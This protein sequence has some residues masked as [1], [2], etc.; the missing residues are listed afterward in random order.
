MRRLLTLA[1]VLSTF[2]TA[3]HADLPTLRGPITGSVDRASP[4]SATAS[5]FYGIGFDPLMV[6][7]ITGIVA[8]VWAEVDRDDRPTSP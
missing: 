2:A 4:A 5:R 8:I 1:A 6:F 3:A 7:L